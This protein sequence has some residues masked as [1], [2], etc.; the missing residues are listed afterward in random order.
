[1]LPH[2]A[3]GAATG[4][5]VIGTVATLRSI[6][7]IITIRTTILTATSTARDRVIGSTI[8]NTAGM[9]RMA[10]EI[11]PINLADVAP[12]E[13]VALVVLEDPVERAGLVVLE[14]PVERAGLV[15]LEDPVERVALV[16]PEDPVEPV[17]L[18]VLEDPA[19]RV[20]LVVPENP[21]ARVAL[22]VPEDPAEP[23]V[24]ELQTVPVAVLEGEL[25]QVAVVLVRDHLRARLAVPLRRKSVTAAHR[26]DLV[27]LLTVGEDLAAAVAETTLEQAA[28]GVVKAWAAAE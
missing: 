1:M 20:A 7:I 27:P 19:E 21:G 16:A 10:T 6:T 14:D 17:A 13:R 12:V 2:G 28:A 9:P 15:V 4:A 25:D 26:P 11:R 24:L 3:L 8:R 18:V 22:V 5:I 23:V